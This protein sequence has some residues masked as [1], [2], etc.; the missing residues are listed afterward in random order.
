MEYNVGDKVF[1]RVSPWKGVLQ[2]G[3]KGKLSPRYI[4]CEY[5]VQ[6]ELRVVPQVHEK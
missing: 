2:F 5:V 6:P 4:D 1:L 3:K